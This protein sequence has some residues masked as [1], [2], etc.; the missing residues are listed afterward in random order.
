[1]RQRIRG[2]ALRMHYRITLNALPLTLSITG[3]QVHR[4]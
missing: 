4:F 3:S 2:A 1:M